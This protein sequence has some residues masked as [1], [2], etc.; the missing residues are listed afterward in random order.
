M[1]PRLYK[2]LS[3]KADS[4]VRLL[5][6]PG[7]IPQSMQCSDVFLPEAQLECAIATCSQDARG[8]AVATYILQGESP[9]VCGEDRRFPVSAGAGKVFGLAVRP[10]GR[11]GPVRLS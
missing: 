9:V 6:E 4:G 7:V 8:V 2:G 3:I 1:F 11:S 10:D 5:L